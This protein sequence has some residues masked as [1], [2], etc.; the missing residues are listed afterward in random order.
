M[1]N[2]AALVRGK[3]RAQ[4]EMFVGG[5]KYIVIINSVSAK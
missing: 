5:N 1:V 4:S 2:E 3:S